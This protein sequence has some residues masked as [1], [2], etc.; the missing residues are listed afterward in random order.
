MLNGLQRKDEIWE[1]FRGQDMG[2][3]RLSAAGCPRDAGLWK[4]AGSSTAV[5]LLRLGTAALL[6]H[7]SGHDH[8]EN[9]L[10]GNRAVNAAVNRVHAIIAQDEILARAAHDQLIAVSRPGVSEGA[11]TQIR[12]IQLPAIDVNAAVFQING[13]SRG[14]DDAFDGKA[15]IG[16]V[17]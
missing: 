3:A 2:G 15:V 9:I 16:G 12:F 4:A 13:I 5:L 8:T 10:P 1:K 17:A 14:G 11:G 7:G 6:C